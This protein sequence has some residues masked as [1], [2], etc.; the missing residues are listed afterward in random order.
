MDEKLH[1]PMPW[2]RTLCCRSIFARRIYIRKPLTLTY[3]NFCQVET[4]FK[5]FTAL[6]W[7]SWR[8]GSRYLNTLLMITINY[9]FVFQNHIH[10]TVIKLLSFWVQPLV[11]KTM[12]HM[13]VKLLRYWY[14]PDD[15]RDRIASENVKYSAFYTLLETF[16][17]RKEIFRYL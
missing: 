5:V 10:F 16:H 17:T 8:V 4:V 6:V 9:L 15:S 1:L 2:S 14:I 7:K 3:E 13:K 11:F 12:R